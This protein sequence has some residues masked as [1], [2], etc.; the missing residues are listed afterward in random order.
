ML[1]QRIGGVDVD[2]VV[3]LG[4]AQVVRLGAIFGPDDQIAAEQI[5]DRALELWLEIVV[6]IAAE[7]EQARLVGVGPAHGAGDQQALRQEQLGR[8]DIVVRA[9]VVLAA[10]RADDRALVV[11]LVLKADRDLGQPAVLIVDAS[12][13][14]LDL[15]ADDVLGEGEALAETQ[16]AHRSMPVSN[17][18]RATDS[19]TRSHRPTAAPT[20]TEAR[21]RAGRHRWRAGCRRSRPRRRS[22]WSRPRWRSRRRPSPR[23]WKRRPVKQKLAA[24]PAL[25]D[26]V[27]RLG[28]D[29]CRRRRGQTDRQDR[30][31][32]R[33]G[34]ETF[35]PQESG[36]DILRTALARH[37]S[38]PSCVRF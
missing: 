11:G 4:E 34:H 8:G 23:W 27:E 19:S 18:W 38:G 16:Q 21:S 22:R 12:P 3:L 29:S 33:H 28:Q 20:E 35:S 17:S 1:V 6:A 36:C 14:S 24:C 10:D 30:R 7:A 32:A 13:S 5:A 15:H 26:P 37:K 9:L 25:R 31:W 2:P